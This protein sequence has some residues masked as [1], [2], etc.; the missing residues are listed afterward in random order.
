MTHSEETQTQGDRLLAAGE[1]FALL[2]VPPSSGWALLAAGKIPRPLKLGRRTRWS[3]VA[4]EQWIREQH[5]AA[6]A[7]AD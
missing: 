4:L 3:R 7:A 1:A 6:Q 2:G 5:Q